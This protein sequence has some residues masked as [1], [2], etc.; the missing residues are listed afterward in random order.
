MNAFG[1]LRDH[2]VRHLQS[3]CEAW[4]SDVIH[5]PATAL[6]GRDFAPNQ[7]P[8]ALFTGSFGAKEL[9]LKSPGNV[10]W[11]DVV[12]GPTCAAAETKGGG[13]IGIGETRQFHLPRKLP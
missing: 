13:P 11:G 1:H 10:S 12:L 3:P 9:V 5:R 8:K 4:L 6:S 2:T 7:R